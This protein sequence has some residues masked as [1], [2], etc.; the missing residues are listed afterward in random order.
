MVFNI[1]K[2]LDKE[3]KTWKG[4]KMTKHTQGPWVMIPPQ[5][6]EAFGYQIHTATGETIIATG[7]EQENARVASAAPDLLEA[8]IALHSCHRAFSDSENWTVFDDE[9]RLLAENAIAK[10]KGK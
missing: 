7:M 9:V 3:F 4:K 5:N 10:A 2:T 1:G 6:G 8:L